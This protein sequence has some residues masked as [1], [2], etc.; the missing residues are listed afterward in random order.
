MLWIYIAALLIGAGTLL[1]QAVMGHDD[2]HVEH[3][4]DAELLF[5]SPRFW[6]FLALAFGLSGA[7][8]TIF[9]L[10]PSLIVLAIAG[11]AGI[12]SGAFATLVLRALKRG[13]VS[14]S[15]SEHEAIGRIGEVLVPVE[16]GR[17]GKVRVALRGQTLD[18][19]AMGGEHSLTMGTRVIVED[20][21]GG[22]ARVSRAPDEIS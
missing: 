1:I 12:A 7:L 10:A 11:A 20:I 15:S 13:Q 19:M 9:N 2:A 6:T 18:L 8:L 22:I 17:V 3:D 5:L 16:K 4:G 21:E 14:S